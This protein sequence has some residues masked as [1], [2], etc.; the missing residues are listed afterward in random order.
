MAGRAKGFRHNEDTR[1]KIQATQIINRLMKHI[2][3]DEPFLDASQ[4]NAAKTL[5]A[6][7]LP[8]LK[9]VEVTGDENHPLSVEMIERV[10]V[11]SPNKN[12]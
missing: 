5:L 11:E 4:V 2:M 7:T 12:S 9:A 1:K 3:A 8:D 10:I 6:K